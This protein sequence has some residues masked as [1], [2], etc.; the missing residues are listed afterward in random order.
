M[1]QLS[2]QRRKVLQISLTEKSLKIISLFSKKYG[3]SKSIVIERALET[4]AAQYHKHILIHYE[5]VDD[6]PIPQYNEKQKKI[7]E[8]FGGI[9]N[10]IEIAKSKW[11]D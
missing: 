2:N 1:N 8:S 7:I 6:E 5:L 11:L 9:D 10:M 3:T 4:L